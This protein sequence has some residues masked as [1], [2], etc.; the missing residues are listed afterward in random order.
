MDGAAAADPTMLNELDTLRWNWG[1]A[2]EIIVVDD[3]KWRARRRDGLG[4][5]MSA[6]SASELRHQI[7]NDYLLKPIPRVEQ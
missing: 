5:W 1:E 7:L 6:S 4:E 3:V 2:Y